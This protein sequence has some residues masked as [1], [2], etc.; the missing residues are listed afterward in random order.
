MRHFP[1]AWVARMSGATSGACQMRIPHVASLM[2]LRLLCPL[3]RV[4]SRGVRPNRDNAH[5]I[6]SSLAGFRSN[7]HC[8]A[9]TF[10]AQR[11]SQRATR[12]STRAANRSRTA[13]STSLKSRLRSD[14]FLTSLWAFI[15]PSCRFG[16][17]S[18][19]APWITLLF[20]GSARLRAENSKPPSSRTCTTSR[21]AGQAGGRGRQ[22]NRRMCVCCASGS[23][24]VRAIHPRR[25][26]GS[27][28]RE[29]SARQTFSVRVA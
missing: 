18:G 27:K 19:P 25:T 1:S 24:R 5:V 15:L 7:T 20:C 22:S 16:G 9:S 21:P 26:S 23:S 17:G 11:W 4:Q 10:A 12:Q 29:S 3:R 28:R 13:A 8:A 2:R 6:P 14:D